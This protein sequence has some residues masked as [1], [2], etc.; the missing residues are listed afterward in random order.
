MIEMYRTVLPVVETAAR[1]DSVI[2]QFHRVS[3]DM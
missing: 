3:E 2:A 1:S